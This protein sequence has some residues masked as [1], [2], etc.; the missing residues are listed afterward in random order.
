MDLIQRREKLI[1]GANPDQR[2][3]YVSTLS[4]T[5]V[6]GD[7]RAQVTVRYVPDKL[8]LVSDSLGPYLVGLEETPWE[9][10]EALATAI[11][12]DIINE[13]VARWIQIGIAAPTSNAPGVEG[14]SV[15]LEDRQP[16]WE[17][18]S[19]LSRLSLL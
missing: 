3:D 10:L 1:T 9:S 17:N 13:L 4:G 2:M 12:D 18:G 14:H 8:V 16:K 15:M 5:L 11:M 6:W 7:G 19:L